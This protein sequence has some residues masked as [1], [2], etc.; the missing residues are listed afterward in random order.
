M[1]LSR[2]RPKLLLAMAS[3][4]PMAAPTPA[5]ADFF[6][7]PFGYAFHQPIPEPAPNATPRAIA[8]ILGKEGFRLVGGL[9]RRGDQVV[10]TGVDRRGHYR[11]FLIDPYEGEILRSWRIGPDEVGPGFVEAPPAAYRGGPGPEPY[12]GPRAAAEDPL[13]V[14][15]LGGEPRR[16]APQSAALARRAETPARAHAAVRQDNAETRRPPHSSPSEATKPP[17]RA[18][19]PQDRPTTAKPAVAKPAERKAPAQQHSGPTQPQGAAPAPASAPSPSSPAPSPSPVAAPAQPIQAAPEPPR[20]AAPEPAAVGHQ[21]A[22]PAQ[23]TIVPATPAT[24]P[25]TAAAPANPVSAEQSKEPSVGEPA[26][27]TPGG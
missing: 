3:L 21:Q 12:D 17:A 4:A 22:A 16:P 25:P 24:P 9:G 8:G 14:P 18:A 23:Q 11:R 27:P 19:A 1:T 7:R 5:A 13:V 26:K 15:G 2:L 6:F 10:A 20:A